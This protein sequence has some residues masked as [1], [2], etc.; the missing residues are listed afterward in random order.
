MYATADKDILLVNSK[1]CAPA[2]T[3]HSATVTSVNRRRDLSSTAF[4][5]REEKTAKPIGS[6]LALTER[7]VMIIARHLLAIL[8]CPFLAAV[9]VPF[10]LLTSWADFDTRWGNASSWEWLPRCVGAGLLAGGLVLF[11]WCVRLFARIGQGTLAPW[12]PTRKLVAVGPYRYV[13]NPMIAAFSLCCWA[14]R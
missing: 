12:D 11:S 3:R 4:P 7:V 6:R 2:G 9:V 14:K 10:W 13:R 1:K 5:R 8:L